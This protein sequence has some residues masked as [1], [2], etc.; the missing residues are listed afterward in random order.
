MNPFEIL[1]DIIGPVTRKVIYVVF[2]VAAIVYKVLE[3]WHDPD[4]A[5]L[6][7]CGEILTFLGAGVALLAAS[8][9]VDV[10]GKHEA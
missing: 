6:N 8:N 10:L 7:K 1:R 3:I 2:A 4:P 5:W 9:V